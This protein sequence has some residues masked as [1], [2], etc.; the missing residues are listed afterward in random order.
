MIETIST[1][2]ALRLHRR[3]NHYGS[4]IAA[5]LFLS[6]ATAAGFRS[7]IGVLIVP[8][9]DEFGWSRTTISV[10]VAINLILY[11]LGG[12]FAAGFTIRSEFAA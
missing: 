9:Q 10:A 7:T 3:G 11:G 6:L 12:P 2:L 1:N 4:V 5:V 8:L